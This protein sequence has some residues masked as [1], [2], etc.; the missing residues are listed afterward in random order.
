V[1]TATTCTVSGTR[2]AH[3]PRQT[4]TPSTA[5]GKQ[6]RLCAGTGLGLL[7]QIRPAEPLGGV[8]ETLGRFGRLPGVR[9]GLKGARGGKGT[10]LTTGGGCQITEV[11]SGNGRQMGVT[12]IAWNRARGDR[13]GI[14]PLDTGGRVGALSHD[15]S[16]ARGR[17]KRAG[18]GLEMGED[19][20]R[21]MGDENGQRMDDESGRGKGMGGVQMRRGDGATRTEIPHGREAGQEAGNGTIHK[22]GAERGLGRDG[23]GVGRKDSGRTRGEN[24]RMLVGRRKVSKDGHWKRVLTPR[25]TGG[26]RCQKKEGKLGKNTRIDGKLLLTEREQRRRKGQRRTWST[27][28]RE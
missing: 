10:K 8:S 27:Q 13:A 20:G 5:V 6:E 19:G 28:N 16:G 23:S 22:D 17:Q 12:G 25:V 3:S 24:G 2:A 26:M 21:R 18:A 7:M 14:G 15:G 1:A 9:R 4:L 11:G